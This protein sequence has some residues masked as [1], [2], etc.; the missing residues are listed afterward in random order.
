MVALGP[1]TYQSSSYCLFTGLFHFPLFVIRPFSS[2]SPARSVTHN[3]STY[4]KV[5]PLTSLRHG[6]ALSLSA[7]FRLVVLPAPCKRIHSGPLSSE[8]HLFFTLRTLLEYPPLLVMV[9]DCIS[10]PCVLAQLLSH[11]VSPPCSPSPATP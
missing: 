11:T 3:W 10:P 7:V 2:S 9:H 4:S 8:K 6:T 1:R 5:V